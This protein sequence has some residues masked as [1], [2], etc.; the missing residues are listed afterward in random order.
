LFQVCNPLGSLLLE[1]VVAQDRIGLGAY[2]A[3]L[4]SELIRN[5]IHSR[6]SARIIVATG[7]SQFEVL[8]SLVKTPGIDWSKVDG[9]HLDEYIGLGINHP[10]SFCGY[11][12]R[13]FVDRIPL[14][15]F[16]FL[17][18]LR[19][20]N[21]VCREA[22]LAV[23][24]A[25]IDVALVGIGEN[26]H[27]AFNDPPADFE[28]QSAYHTVK[29]D[30]ACRR[31]QVGEGWFDKLEQVPTMAMSMTIH[32]IMASHAIICSVPDRRKST[33]VAATLQGKISPDVPASILQQHTN[34]NL[35]LDCASSSDLSAQW[36]HLARKV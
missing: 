22:G 3:N 10:A 27:L 11:L 18:G 6:G 30:E 4:A 23:Q 2:S 13:R 14:R 24:A 36:L 19:E 16:L 17:D 1:V 33:A 26:G 34:V 31:Q 15:S 29:L 35:V 21:E 25:P 28:T 7:S 12:K 8:D 9:F 5:A 20:A 32:Q